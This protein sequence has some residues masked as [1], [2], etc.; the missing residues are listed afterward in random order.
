MVVERLHH[1]NIRCA[2]A[3]LEA[4]ERFYTTV[5]GL[6]RGPRPA[7]LR[8]EGLWMYL[9]DQPIVHVTAR[10][11][12]GDIDIEH[13]GSV[14]HIALQSRGAAEF[15]ARLERLG[16]ARKCYKGNGFQVFVTDP[17]GTQIEFN[18]PDSEAPAG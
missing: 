9:G 12:P 1:F 17:V 2:P 14:D 15:L 16:I 7:T 11:A 13:R 18:F 8:N 10:C 3:D 6:Q 5:A 4:I